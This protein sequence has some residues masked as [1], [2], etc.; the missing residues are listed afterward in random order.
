MHLERLCKNCALACCICV[1]VAMPIAGKVFSFEGGELVPRSAMAF[2]TNT[3]SSSIA[4]FVLNTTIR[5]EYSAKAVPRPP[6]EER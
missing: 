2:A 3:S 5:G 6:H 1:G 4:T